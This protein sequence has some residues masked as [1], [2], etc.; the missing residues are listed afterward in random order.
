MDTA[1][2]AC[3]VALRRAD[4]V[5]FSRWQN[6]GRTHSKDLFELISGVFAAARV[7]PSQVSGIICGVGPGSFTG[8]R[9]GLGVAKGFAQAKNIEI[10]PVSSLEMLAEKAL[11]QTMPEDGTTI[12]A[13]MDARMGQVYWQQ[14][15][16]KDQQ[17]RAASEPA[18]NDPQDVLWTKSFKN[19]VGIGNGFSAEESYL[20]DK[21]GT[22][23]SLLLEDELPDVADV[24]SRVGTFWNSLDK[25]SANQLE[26][27][28]LRNNV[29]MTS[30]E[31]VAARLEKAS[32]EDKAE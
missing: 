15:A 9:I 25:V 11:E 19:A 8:V 10:A 12:V 31:Q 27:L 1:T 26:P 18:L 17:L 21:Y 2:P 23:F 29:A 5:I 32:R 3:S 22:Q 28:Y 13:C 20:K 6:S 14:F 16:V 7:S 30:A 24:I 4:G